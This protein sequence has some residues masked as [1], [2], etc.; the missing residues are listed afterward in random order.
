MVVSI[1]VTGV[2]AAIKKIQKLGTKKI[3]KVNAT[4]HKQGFLLESEIKS[5]IAGQRGEPASVDTG[6]FLRSVNTKNQFLESTVS[7]DVS[8]AKF[9][10]QGTRFMQARK[11]F[12]NSTKRR[13]KPIVNAIKNAVK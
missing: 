9:L 8:Y 5:S 7:T 4:L 3:Q 6:N 13:R 12:E 10:E 1:S 2:A 11:H